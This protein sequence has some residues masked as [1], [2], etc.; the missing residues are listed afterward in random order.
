MW[1]YREG[2]VLPVRVLLR[3][4]GYTVTKESPVREMECRQ[5]AG[6]PAASHVK[7]LARSR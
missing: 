6:Y 5:G 7:W 4:K 2:T 3:M 1:V